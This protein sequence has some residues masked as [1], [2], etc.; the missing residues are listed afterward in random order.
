MMSRGYDYLLLLDRA[1]HV[2]GSVEHSEGKS[3]ESDVAIP[4][5]LCG[6]PRPCQLRTVPFWPRWQALSCV[7]TACRIF[8]GPD[9]PSSFCNYLVELHLPASCGAFTFGGRMR[10]RAKISSREQGPDF[11]LVGT[12]ER[13]SYVRTSES[14][15]YGV[16]VRFFPL[17]GVYLFESL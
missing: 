12:C 7:L 4:M 5:F 10:L 13:F 16:L 15:A 2:G 14:Q 9:K 11:D 8:M 17:Q 1:G 3:G 6:S